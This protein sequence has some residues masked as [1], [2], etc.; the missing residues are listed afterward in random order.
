MHK[1]ASSSYSV[2]KLV[3]FPL[4]KSK[5]KLAFANSHF[6]YEDADVKIVA[7]CSELGFSEPANKNLDEQLKG[8]LQQ[9]IDRRYQ[10]S[11]PDKFDVFTIHCP[12]STIACRF[13][14][15]ANILVCN[16]E[17]DQDKQKFLQQILHG[18]FKE[19]DTLEMPKAL[20]SPHSFQSLGFPPDVLLPPFIRMLSQY[21]FTNDD[22][23]TEVKFSAAS[24][25]DLTVLVAIAE[26]TLG[27]KGH[28]KDNYPGE[29]SLL[30]SQNSKKER[31]M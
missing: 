8:S 9:T 13:L 7:V 2:P 23:L 29:G 28:R 12:P 18:V 14:V 17:R 16:V 20:V 27:T 26:H 11:K 3:E 6:L 24:Q 4:Q 22:F 15:V 5:H 1:N 19:A 30:D 21:H 10:K 25:N 31:G